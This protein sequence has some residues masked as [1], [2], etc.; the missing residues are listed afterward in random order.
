M[1]PGKEMQGG[2]KRRGILP[3]AYCV[4]PDMVSPPC[5]SA[6]FVEAYEATPVGYDNWVIP[7]PSLEDF[8]IVV[9]AV[10]AWQAIRRSL[11]CGATSAGPSVYLC[12]EV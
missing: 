6:P 5:T 9:G 11:N 8:Q 4:T 10:N 1:R 3:R 7:E 2:A 12:R